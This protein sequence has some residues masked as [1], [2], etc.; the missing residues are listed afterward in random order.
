LSGIVAISC[1]S[2]PATTVRLW[3]LL[4]GLGVASL[5]VTGAYVR[6]GVFTLFFVS[7]TAAVA[8]QAWG[9]ALPTWRRLPALIFALFLLD[10][11]PTAIQPWARPDLVPLARASTYLADRSSE[12]RVLE[13]RFTK[14]H[15]DISVG[16]D[17]SPLLYSRI[18]AL[19]GPHKMDATKGH[20][21]MAAVS[22]LAETDLTRSGRLGSDTIG[23]LSLYNVGWIV[24][25]D[26]A[27]LGL[28]AAWTDVVSDPILGNVE[29]I[30]TATP[31]LVSG[32]IKHVARPVS[33]GGPPLWNKHF[34]DGT[35]RAAEQDAVSAWKRMN[36]DLGMRQAGTILVPDTGVSPP[37]DRADIAGLAPRA[38]MLD[39]S[40]K[41]GRVHLAVTATGP[42]F[43]RLAHPA[44]PTLRV[45]VDGR[46]VQPAEDIF[47]M[48][49]V[50]LHDGLNDIEVVAGTSLLRR[51]CFWITAASMAT[52]TFA[53]IV[54]L[55]AR[56]Y[57]G[58]NMR[59]PLN[60]DDVGNASFD[61]GDR[62]GVSFQG[63]AVSDQL[64]SVDFG[65]DMQHASE[66]IVVEPQ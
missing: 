31:F 53:L 37:W 21:A 29:R 36:V 1:R 25:L 44:F 35:G 10:M 7:A 17:A 62:P 60:P 14:G 8:V 3:V 49:V 19:Y 52:L 50:P 48:M 33:F 45:T 66:R 56:R 32:T 11:G 28:P 55:L 42:G 39:Y 63:G 30:G 61:A 23:L 18:Q 5:A 64:G 20:N 40:V 46:P 12:Q 51:I 41:P 65:A 43:L 54:L 6:D 38:T 34:V 15:P 57:H 59:R 16:P 58:W 24:G 9:A 47:S 4:G 27:R 2:V 13:I 22:K 26:G